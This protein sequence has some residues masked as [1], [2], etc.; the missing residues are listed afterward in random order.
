MKQK[1]LVIV[2]GGMAGTRLM[3]EVVAQDAHGCSC[4]LGAKADVVQS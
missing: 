3:E 2:G 4:V 1:R